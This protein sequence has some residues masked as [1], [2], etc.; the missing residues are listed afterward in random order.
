MNRIKRTGLKLGLVVWATPIT[1]SVLL[2]VHAQT[3]ICTMSDLVG[4]WQFIS[5]THIVPALN[6][7]FK[8][9]ADGS[10]CRF[11]R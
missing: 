2:P 6:P 8:L 10:T 7:T 11:S 9:R 4:I 1:T 5:S 3:S